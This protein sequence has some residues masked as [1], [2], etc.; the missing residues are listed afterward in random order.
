MLSQSRLKEVLHYDP[1]TGVFTWLV[2]LGG[3]HNIGT[4]ANSVD[5]KGYIRIQIDGRRYRAHRLAWF[6]VYGNWPKNNIDHRDRNRKNN[7]I[8]NLRDRTQAENMRNTGMRPDNTSGYKG[9]TWDK[10]NQKWKA[11]MQV[12][13]RM[14]FLGRFSKIKDAVSARNAAEKTIKGYA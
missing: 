8:N 6:Y 13:G 10:V 3:R 14:K 5:G 4:I 11:Q 1:D 9:V 7:R 12:D 2:K